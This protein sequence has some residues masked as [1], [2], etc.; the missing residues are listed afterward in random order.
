M[1]SENDIEKLIQPIVDRQQ[2]ISD[3]VINKIAQRVKEIGHLLPSDVY[4]LER[5]L[6][7]GS[8]VRE[9][10][11]EIA[12]LSGLNE[13]DIKSLIRTV[14]EDSYLMVKPFYDYRQKPFIS[15]EKNLIS[16]IQSFLN[17]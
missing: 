14:A 8:D 15:F 1:L 6:Q 10:N 7:S 3:Y 2:S 12:R 5:L 17:Y 16:L 4:K 11:A 9:I 13:R